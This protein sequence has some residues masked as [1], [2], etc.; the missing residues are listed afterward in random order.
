LAPGELPAP[1][2][3]GIAPAVGRWS[4]GEGYA[5]FVDAGGTGAFA[6]RCDSARREL[7]FLRSGTTDGGALLRIVTGMAAAAY[8]A[9]TTG[10]RVEARAGIDDR[11]LAALQGAKGTIGVSLGEGPVLA[12]PADP[13][14]GAVIRDCRRP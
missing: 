2:L 14:I 6:L 11:F 5:R 1:E 4:S 3:A 10:R 9:T 8:P 7:V 12:V 13:A